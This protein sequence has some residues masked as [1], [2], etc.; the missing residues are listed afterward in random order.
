MQTQQLRLIV[1]LSINNKLKPTGLS[2]QIIHNMCT[3]PPGSA[4]EPYA[5]QSSKG[6][7]YPYVSNANMLIT[8]QNVI[9][10]L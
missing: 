7:L 6:Y 2:T 8:L 5:Q 10:I 3:L 4:T 9:Y 1:E